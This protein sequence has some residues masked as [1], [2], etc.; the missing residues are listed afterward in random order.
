M[1]KGVVRAERLIDPEF[2]IPELIKRVEPE[3]LITIYDVATWTDPQ[4]FLEKMARKNGKLL[5]GGEPDVKTAAK[6]MIY[7]WT[8][9]RIPFY[10]VP[11]EDECLP[12]IDSDDENLKMLENPKKFL[13]V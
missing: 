5:K 7:D 12:D 3:Q 9:G 8:R 13:K 2:Y 11:P 6:M 1:L 4:D 10:N